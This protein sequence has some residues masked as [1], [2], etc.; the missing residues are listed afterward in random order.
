MD[1]RFEKHKRTSV[2]FNKLAQN[3]LEISGMF[4]QWFKS[5]RAELAKYEREKYKETVV[6][7]E[8]ERKGEGVLLLLSRKI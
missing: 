5:P 2:L 6:E 7:M 1:V 4:P 3:K 8:L